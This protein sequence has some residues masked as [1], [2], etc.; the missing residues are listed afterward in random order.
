VN[1][2]S[3]TDD[4]EKRIAKIRERVG[5][6]TPGPWTV[7][8][9]IG[10][11]YPVAQVPGAREGNK[12]F[13]IEAGLPVRASSRVDGD[14]IAHSRG[15][16]EWLCAQLEVARIFNPRSGEERIEDRHDPE[17]RVAEGMIYSKLADPPHPVRIGNFRDE[18]RLAVKGRAVFLIALQ[19]RGGTSET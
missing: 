10:G 2:A 12:W 9:A 11:L 15:D 1:R 5:A 16:V 8:Q 17:F 3:V 19:R 13:T 18:Q 4:V 6:A 14:F 7:Q